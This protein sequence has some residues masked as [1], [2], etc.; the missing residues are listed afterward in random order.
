MVEIQANFA[1]Y[2]AISTV[3]PKAEPKT[4]EA[5]ERSADR[6]IHDTVDIS[7]GG[8]KVANL[9]RSR[10]LANEIRSRPV[11]ENFATELRKA[12]EDVFRITRLFKESLRIA[13]LFKENIKAA[14]KTR[15]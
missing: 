14:F 13:G 5:V 12:L 11:D 10:E 8:G 1:T 2:K 6:T 4:G 7:G 15:L 9:A 3:A